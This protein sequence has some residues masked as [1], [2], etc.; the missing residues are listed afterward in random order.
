MGKFFLFFL[1]FI[2]YNIWS[3]AY[4]VSN[5]GSD[6]N[7]GI[8][9]LASW[10]SILKINSFKFSE[11]DRIL[12][13]RG[14]VFFGTLKLQSN[15]ISIDSYGEGNKPI[16]SGEEIL[17]NK[18]VKLSNDIWQYTFIT[19][20]PQ[21]INGLVRDDKLLPIS[22]MPNKE[23]GSGYFFMDSVGGN[24]SFSS[25]QL[26]GLGDL[27][28]FEVVIRAERFRMVRTKILNSR[29]NI[30]TINGTQS[31]KK[32]NKGF[33]FF[34][35]NTKDAIDKQGEWCYNSSKGILLLK[36]KNNPNVN[37]IKY[38][39]NYY[40]IEISG[41]SGIILKNLEL[42][43]TAKSAV[44]ISNSNNILVENIEVSNI[45][46]NGI[47]LY[48]VVNSKINN[49]KLYNIAW[50]GIF[51]DKTNNNLQI[52]NNNIYDI[53][54]ESYAKSKVF[55]GIDCNASFSK[56]ENNT[57]KN[58][59]YSGII[60]AGI[61][62]LIRYNIIDSTCISLNDSGGIY[63][64]NNINDV[65]G[66]II[67]S[68]FISNTIGELQGAPSSRNL[69]NGIYI[70]VGSHNVI[71]KNNTIFDI[72]GS[73]L[74]INYTAGNNL[75][76][77][78]IVSNCGLSE[79][80]I[81]GHPSSSPKLT[82]D[83]NVFIS[84][85]NASSS[86]KMFNSEYTKKYTASDI[87]VFKH[88]YFVSSSTANQINISFFSKDKNK[89]IFTMAE[90][91]TSLNHSSSSDNNFFVNTNNSILIS[92]PSDTI[93]LVKIGNGKYTSINGDVFSKEIK[94]DAFQSEVLFI[95]NHK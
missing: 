77:K 79:F 28:G 1:F 7:S 24:S 50:T 68:N 52:S 19:E 31:I 13:H 67:E 88:N 15:N 76:Y 44:N 64:N 23:T 62:N 91:I 17:N 32:L 55:I 6:V 39:K 87:G 35:V 14:D 78:N 65:G 21:N 74:F 84:S 89:N 73:G 41:C 53:G 51:A 11:G 5:S 83:S 43:H 33:G 92:N 26:Q 9:Q 48:N 75:I 82:I 94:L 37:R 25:K 71:V 85:K 45:V 3:K 70:D 81:A 58:T 86:H 95:K 49:C 69:A 61:N 57:I 40:N 46:G 42:K 90:W 36:D 10:N 27:S 60:S 59:G 2:H 56:I 54:D 8:S 63:L 38:I 4:Y 30:I 22:R 47:S 72:N 29:G 20:K 18:W 80:Y 93:K 12:F 66:T 34:I 16:F